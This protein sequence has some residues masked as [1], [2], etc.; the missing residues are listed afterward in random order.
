MEHTMHKTLILR[1]LGLFSVALSMDGGKP[2]QTSMPYVQKES[3]ST[4]TDNSVLTHLESL[5]GLML[6]GRTLNME[7]FS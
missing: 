6:T 4:S 1:E 5:Y 7:G 3:I 2:I